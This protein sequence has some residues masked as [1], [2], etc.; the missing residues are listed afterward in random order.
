MRISIQY[1]VDKNARYDDYRNGEPVF[2]KEIT[3]RILRVGF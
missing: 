2:V 3:F 1:T